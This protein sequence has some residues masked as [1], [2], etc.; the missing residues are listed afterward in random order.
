[1]GALQKKMEIPSHSRYKTWGKTRSNRLP[2]YDYSED[3]PIFVTICADNQK[4]IFE[5]ETNARPVIEE[6]LRTIRDLKF[7]LLC[8]CL[9]PD[10]LHILISPA[11]SGVPL[12][13]FLNIFKGSTTTMFRKK[14]GLRKTWQKSAYDHVVRADENLK[15]V[16]QYIMNN[17]VRKGITEKA[18][19]YPFSEWFESEVAKYL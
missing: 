13:K 1:M 8:Y 11:D 14:H 19:E 4:D 7:R 2:D 10:H 5:S 18:E 9:M 15:D 16:I 17:P 3:R 6:L 12:P